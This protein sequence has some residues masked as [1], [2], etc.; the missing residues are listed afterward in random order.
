LLALEVAESDY[1]DVIEIIR[2][3]D[4]TESIDIVEKYSIGGVDRFSATLLTGVNTSSTRRSRCSSTKD[5][6]RSVASANYI[7]ELKALIYY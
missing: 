6:F 1:D 3:H 5:S 4:S 2:E 7:I